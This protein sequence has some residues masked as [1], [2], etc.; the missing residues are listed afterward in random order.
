MDGKDLTLFV[1]TNCFVPN[2]TRPGTVAILF[3]LHFEVQLDLQAKQQ[4]W[5]HYFDKT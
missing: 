1:A 4:L 2:I 3:S 5:A